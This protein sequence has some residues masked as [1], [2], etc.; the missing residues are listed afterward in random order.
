MK[1]VL[2]VMFGGAVGSGLR[3]WVG[4]MLPVAQGTFPVPTFLVNVLG[5]FILGG[6]VGATSLPSPLSRNAT[7]LLGTGLCGGFTTYS[8]FAIESVSLFEGGNVLVAGTYLATTIVCCMLAAVAGVTLIRF[9]I[10]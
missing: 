1:E 7:L 8:A 6:I 4:T 9:S 5:S 3:Y 10:Q 2:L